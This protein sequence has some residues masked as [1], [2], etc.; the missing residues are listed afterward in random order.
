MLLKFLKDIYASSLLTDIVENNHQS[1][2]SVTLS[3]G[4]IRSAIDFSPAR[5]SHTSQPSIIRGSMKSSES[6]KLIEGKRLLTQAEI[7]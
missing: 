5:T 7:N 3:A 2:Y 1:A 6:A 4:Q